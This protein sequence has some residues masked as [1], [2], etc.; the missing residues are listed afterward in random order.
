MTNPFRPQTG[1]TWTSD[2]Y[3]PTEP[4]PLPTGAGV[5][6]APGVRVRIREVAGPQGPA[7]ATGPTGA[8]GSTGPQG[9]PGDT[10]P[11]GPVG[12]AGGSSSPVEFS[13]DLGAGTRSGSFVYT[14]SGLTTGRPYQVWQ[15]KTAVSSKGGATDEFDMQPIFLTGQATSSTQL[16]ISWWS[17]APVVGTYQ[18]AYKE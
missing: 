11:A 6:V 17:P 15:T 1:I 18:F 10:G 16:S 14:T 8:V 13:Q 4:E 12:P 9:I 2:P 3:V 5:E 7:G